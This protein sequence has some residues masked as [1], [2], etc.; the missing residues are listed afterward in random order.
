MRTNLPVTDTEYPLDDDAVLVSMTD[1]DSH[2]IY[3]NPTFIE[4]SGFTKESKPVDSLR[5]N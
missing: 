3:A 5:K 4:A 1:L 2:I